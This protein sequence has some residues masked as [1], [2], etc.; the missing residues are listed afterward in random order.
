MRRLHPATVIVVILPK[1]RE[2]VQAAVPVLVGSLASNHSVNGEWIGIGIGGLT[3]FFA[4]GAYWTTR[5]DIEDNHVVHRTGWVFRKDRRIP[6]EQIQNVNLRQNLLERLFRVATV[7]VETAMG[8]GRDLKLSVMG[9]SAAEQFREELLVASHL[10]SS[11]PAKAEEPLVRLNLHDLTL[12]A[13]TE[14]HLGQVIALQFILWGPVIGLVTKLADRLPPDLSAAAYAGAAFLM[15]LGS[16]LWGVASYF[17]K[18]GGFEVRSGEH[19]FRISYGLLNKVQLVIRPQ[20]IEYL[21]VMA[22]L[23]QRWMGRASFHVGT[24]SSFGEAGVL[25]PVAL[26][27]DRDRAYQSAAGVISNLDIAHLNWRPF[28]PI[29][30]RAAVARALMWLAVFYGIGTLLSRAHMPSIALW[31]G[32]GL[33]AFLI[34]LNLLGLFLSKAENGFAIT[35]DALVVRRGYFHQ[36]ISAMPIARMENVAINQPFWWK[37]YRAVSLTAQAMKHRISAG[38]VSD[39]AAEELR[40]RWVE[41]IESRERLKAVEV[42]L[43]PIG[44][45]GNAK[46]ESQTIAGDA[47]N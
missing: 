37:P 23:P 11:G 45:A 35:D 25:A 26:F 18:Y 30:Y 29:F 7:D 3:G 36:R 19:A 27:V 46:E 9:F 17:L 38:A 34:L 14:N 5:F 15:I 32:F 8:K 33:L 31:I 4:I 47:T 39:K 40:Q 42:S 2:A 13:F 41:K 22:T 28:E 16:W 44:F 12:G 21:Q 1:L 6:L 24:A 20:R 10:E 43:D